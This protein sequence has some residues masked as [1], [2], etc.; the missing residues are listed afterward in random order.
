MNE[1]GKRIVMARDVATRWI[2]RVAKPE[3]RLR[4]YSCD[5]KEW[6]RKLRCF[7]DGKSVMAGVKPAGDLGIH[8]EFDVLEVWSSNRT[9]V[10]QIKEWF[11]TRGFETTGVW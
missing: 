2:L 5:A 10:D 7:R 3:Y 9:T 1:M 11:E 8:E 6:S 4:I